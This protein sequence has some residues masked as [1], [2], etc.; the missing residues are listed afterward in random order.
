MEDHRG[1]DCATHWAGAIAL[2][3]DIPY[4]SHRQVIIFSRVPDVSFGGRNQ[5]R[6]NSRGG[7][8]VCYDST[9]WDYKLSIVRFKQA[10]STSARNSVEFPKQLRHHR[11]LAFAPTILECGTSERPTSISLHSRWHKTKGAERR[12]DRRRTFPT[13][14]NGRVNSSMV[15]ISSD[16]EL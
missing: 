3:H 9:D 4:A 15:I 16:E 10:S 7:K 13:K 1:E 5:F 6:T 14:R 11:T 2:R 8:R 12:C